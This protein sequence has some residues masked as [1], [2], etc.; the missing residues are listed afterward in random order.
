MKK[1]FLTGLVILMPLALTILIIVFLVDLFTD[2]F[3]NFVREIIIRNVEWIHSQNLITILSRACILVFIFFFIL[4][5]G[6]LGRLFF[7]KWFLSIANKILS[8]IPLIKPIYKTTKDIVHAFFQQE[9]Q[10]FKRPIMVRFPSDD[11][12]S[13]GFITGKVPDVCQKHSKEVLNPVFVPTAPHPISGFMLFV[14]DE[15]KFEIDMTNEDAVKL[16]VSCGVIV[17][18]EK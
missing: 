3:L 18:E 17:P 6:F 16:T 14:P 12:L 4:F 11:S 9:S 10:A 15:R 1:A 5:L 2:P 8:K 13:I 7:I